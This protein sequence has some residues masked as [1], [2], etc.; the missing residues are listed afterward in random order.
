M[1]RTHSALTIVVVLLALSAT[2][3]TAAS[4]TRTVLAG[5]RAI[6][7]HVDAEGGGRA[8]AFPIVVRSSGRLR[9][10]DVYVDSFTTAKTLHVALYRNRRGHPG[11]RFT[12]ALR[13]HLVRAG[14]NR[15]PLHAI[16]VTAGHKYWLAILGTGGR[17]GFRDREPGTCHSQDST[18]RHLRGLP[19]RWR[20]ASRRAECPLSA[21]VA[22]SVVSHAGTGGKGGGSTSKPTTPTSPTNPTKPPTPPTTHCISQLAACG[23]PDGGNNDGAHGKLT[24]VNGTVVLDK[25]GET[26]ANM[27]VNGSI[28]VRANNVTI[29]NVRVTTDGGEG[30]MIYSGNVDVPVNG[31]TI[32]DTTVRGAAPTS[33]AALTDGVLNAG[34]NGST[35]ATRL[36]I[37]N[38]GSTDW[39]G[40]GAISDSYM[41]V[42]TYVS[43]AHDEA[44]YEPGGDAGAQLNHDTMLNNQPQTAVVFFSR[45]HG[46][47]AHD[48]ISNSV[49]AGGGYLV[50]GAHGPTDPTP[51]D[52]PRIFDNRLVRSPY[53][54]F[55][56]EGGSFGQAVAIDWSTDWWGNYWDDNL[57]RA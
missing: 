6:Q 15:V 29:H 31:T 33:S 47:G 12:T 26:Y 54:G 32:T 55:F 42:D 45:D 51:I 37:Y 14:W 41:M 20:S 17:L 48:L 56:S 24:P 13:R 16:K 40:P 52:G 25:P 39:N 1:R 4:R 34:G 44:V 21:Y 46:A 23:Y 22:L 57:G 8:R 30:I 18:Q 38:S 3:A 7:A 36:Y 2:T 49:M 9:F 43:G 19:S 50:Y 10:V 53:G 5:E 11:S 27:D 35:T 28:A